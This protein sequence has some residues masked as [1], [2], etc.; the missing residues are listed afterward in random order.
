MVTYLLMERCAMNATSL[1]KLGKEHFAGVKV[2]G[3]QLAI[4]FIIANSLTRRRWQNSNGKEEGS[5]CLKSPGL[6]F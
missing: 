6:Y 2:F 1:W 3:P 4:A 5:F